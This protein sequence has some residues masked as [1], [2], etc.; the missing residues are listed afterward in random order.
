MMAALGAFLTGVGIG[1]IVFGLIGSVMS[2][3]KEGSHAS[4]VLVISGVII[5]ALLVL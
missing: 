4:I 1:F 2:Q 5:T 3:T